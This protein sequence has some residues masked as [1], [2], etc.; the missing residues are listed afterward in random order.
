VQE[1]KFAKKTEGMDKKGNEGS[2]I[3]FRMAKEKIRKRR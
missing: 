1:R 3:N 2:G